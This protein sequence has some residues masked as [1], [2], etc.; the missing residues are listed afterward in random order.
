[1]TTLVEMGTQNASLLVTDGDKF[2]VYVTE[3]SGRD[4]FVERA[5]AAAIKAEEMR[6][7]VIPLHADVVTKHGEV[8]STAAEVEQDAEDAANSASNAQISA[9]EAAKSE[10]NSANSAT[11]STEQ[12]GIS[13]TEADRSKREADRA[14]D[15]ANALGDTFSDF[16]AWAVGPD[17]NL[18]PKPDP[19]ISVMWTVSVAG[20]VGEINFNQGEGLI[21]SPH[22]DSDPDNNASGFFKRAGEA[23]IPVPPQD[24]E[25]LEDLIMQQGKEIRFKI[26]DTVEARA[27]R[28][29]TDGDL[30]VGDADWT[31]TQPQHI[32]TVNKLG[33]AAKQTLHHIKEFDET[34]HATELYNIITDENGDVV[35]VTGAQTIGDLK[36]FSVPPQTANNPIHDN[37]LTRRAWVVLELDKK[38]NTGHKHTV[39]DITDFPDEMPPTDHDHNDLYYGKTESDQ[40][41]AKVGGDSSKAFNVANPTGSSNA[42]N[43]GWA[44]TNFVKLSGDQSIGGVKTFTNGVKA[45]TFIHTADDEQG[46]ALFGEGS[47]RIGGSGKAAGIQLRPD[48][49]DFDNKD[50]NFISILPTSVFSPGVSGTWSLGQASARWG[51]VYSISGNFSGNISAN[52]APTDGAHLTN[53]T[54]VDGNFGRL[55]ASN[56]WTAAS[57]KFQVIDDAATTNGGLRFNTRSDRQLAYLYVNQETGK[58]HHAVFKTYD[59]AGTGDRAQIRLNGGT[60]SGSIS[61]QPHTAGTATTIDSS[62]HMKISGNVNAKFAGLEGIN[63]RSA[64]QNIDTTITFRENNEQGMNISYRG[65]LSDNR[66]ELSMLDS[67]K[68][69]TVAYWGR[70]A[71]NPLMLMRRTIVN[72]GQ[73]NPF[74]LERTTGKANINIRFSGYAD[75]TWQNLYAGST[76]GKFAIGSNENLESSSNQYALFGLNQSWIRGQLTFNQSRPVSSN[77]SDIFHNGN[78]GDQ[79]ICRSMRENNSATWVWERISSGQVRYSTGT[80][81]SGATRVAIDVS[82]GGIISDTVG[83]SWGHGLRAAIQLNAGAVGSAYNGVRWSNGARIQALGGT[84]GTIRLYPNSASTSY[85]MIDDSAGLQMS[86][87]DVVAFSASKN[88]EQTNVERFHNREAGE[89]VTTLEAL[90]KMVEVIEEQAAK[91]AELE[92][93]L[94]AVE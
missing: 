72:G 33:L 42:A 57:T 60:S 84:G 16:G 94:E 59:Q 61:L 58:E 30:V 29:D 22:L 64:V 93:R 40:K 36:T 67:G 65:S 68:Y 13:G 32:R 86:N 83:S 53:K 1:M 63:L 19:K 21:Y 79:H 26:A 54:Y 20:N 46:V 37:A 88:N 6:D 85:L 14:Q 11:T 47:T 3:H 75:G 44:E 41:F 35:R 80:T 12:A 66:G 52:K 87:G 24:I 69:N 71:S 51:N 18:P 48:G 43:K 15:I 39:S 5:E 73:S 62:G 8:L 7:E 34:G 78:S 90:N 45:Q 31:E 49:I 81:G 50:T 4:P 74:A 38:S 17:G 9:G 28:L 55:S 27:L 91:I 89:G 77:Q 76:H 2:F 23:L 56:T 82:A 25:I 70:A 92:Q 10:T